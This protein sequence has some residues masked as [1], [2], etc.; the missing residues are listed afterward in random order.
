MYLDTAVLVK[1][2]IREP[3]TDFYADYLDGQ[4]SV[5]SSELAVAEC[6]SALLRKCEV[7]G[8]ERRTCERSWTRLQ[9]YWGNAGGLRLLPLTRIILEE[10]GAV[11]QRCAGFA[12]VRTLDAIH[13]ASCL[14][15]QAYP[16]VT[17]DRVMRRAAERLGIPLAPVPF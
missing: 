1:L 6:R 5:Q 3:D 11:M 16:L 14:L 4:P 2:V 13:L 9:A 15:A 8:L 17:N 10:A 7:G 12:P